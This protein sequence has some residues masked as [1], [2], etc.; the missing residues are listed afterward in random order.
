[1]SGAISAVM[2]SLLIQNSKSERLEY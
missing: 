2:V 1:V